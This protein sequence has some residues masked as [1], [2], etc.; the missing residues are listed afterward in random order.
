MYLT[1]IVGNGDRPVIM[2]FY[3][4]KYQEIYKYE[5]STFDFFHKFIAHFYVEAFILETCNG[6]KDKKI[7]TKQVILE[8]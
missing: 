8:A 1:M 4:K 6:T 3:R 5:D 2:Y 7:K